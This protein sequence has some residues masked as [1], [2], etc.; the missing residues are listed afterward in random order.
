[1]GKIRSSVIVTIDTDALPDWH[2]D[3]SRENGPRLPER[4]LWAQIRHLG[5]NVKAQG[6]HISHALMSNRFPHRNIA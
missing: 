6:M 2:E 1:M 3:E 4:S 5:L